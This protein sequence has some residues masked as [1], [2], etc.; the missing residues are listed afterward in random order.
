MQDS[1]PN[2]PLAFPPPPPRPAPFALDYYAVYRNGRFLLHAQARSADHA[3]AIARQHGHRL[4]R[5]RQAIR[6]G[7]HGYHQA[8][9]RAFRC[10]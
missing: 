10:S 2:S 7:S 8:L 4:P 5:D 6:I 1:K 3:L 9:R